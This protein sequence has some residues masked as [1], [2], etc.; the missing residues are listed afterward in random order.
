M[1]KKK[2]FD[3]VK[4]YIESYD[5]YILLSQEYKNSKTPLI[6]QC[7]NNHTFNIIYN[8]FQQGIRCRKCYDIKHTII[9]AENKK[10]K[11]EEI[12]RYVQ[13]LNYTVDLSNYEHN[14]QHLIFTCPFG[15]E[16]MMKWNVFQSGRRCPKCKGIKNGES[17]RKSIVFIKEYL[18]Q[19]GFKLVQLEYKNNKESK[20]QLE[21]NNGHVFVKN[22]LQVYK[23]KE[24]CPECNPNWNKW[25]IK[26]VSK[27]ANEYGYKVLSKK[28]VS[29]DRKLLFQCEQNHKFKMS[30]AGFYSCGYRC[31]VCNSSKGETAISSYLKENNLVFER[32]YWFEDCRDKLPLRFDFAVFNN[33]NY[34]MC[35]IEFDGLQHYQAVES[36][37]GEKAYK[38]TVMRDKI[39]NRYCKE[40]NI[41]LIRIPYWKIDKINELLNN[42]LYSIHIV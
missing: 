14:K 36:F 32:E 26:K 9:E 23:E 19:Q 1:P 27:V 41:K 37:G 38:S 33:N 34:L 39:K 21:C 30:W 12:K 24:G 18:I 28:Y 35:L 29:V 42:E 10:T 13:V 20:I 31:S 16:F 25:D 17:K 22:W 11:V 5:G 8:A 7:P 40:N 15:H 2:T 6:I 4:Q 3:E